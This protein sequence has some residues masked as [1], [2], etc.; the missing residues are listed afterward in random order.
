MGGSQSIAATYTK[1][2]TRQDLLSSTENNRDF[3][4]KLFQLLISQ[5]TSE[6]LL[7]LSKQ[8]LCSQYVFMMADTIHS[9]FDDLRIRP[10]TEKSSGVVLFKKVDNLK[11]ETKQTREICLTIAYFYV[12]IFQIFSAL[13][14]TVLDDPG[15]GAVLGAVQY[16]EQQ[17]A[18][19]VF[20]ALGLGQQQRIPG[21]RPA[22]AQFGG[23]SMQYFLGEAAK[24]F[25]PIH[26]LFEEG[27]LEQGRV[28]LPLRDYP[29]VVEIIPG[30]ISNRNRKPQNLRITLP[31]NSTLYGNIAA[32]RIGSTDSTPKYKL[33]LNNFESHNSSISALVAI[34]TQISKF[35]ESFEIGSFD[36]GQTWITQSGNAQDRVWMII[37]KVYQI[38]QKLVENP[39]LTLDK[40]KTVQ[41]LIRRKE[42]QVP[43]GPTRQVPYPTTEI[44]V[45]KELMN[46]Y[47]IK[48][49][50]GITEQKT[51]SFCVA[52]ALQLLNAD[53]LFMRNPTQAQSSIC[54][55]KF[56]QFPPSV[57][58]IGESLDK[59][60]GLKVLDQLFHTQPSLGERDETRI[61]VDD[62]ASYAEFL[63]NMI[64]LF[65][66]QATSKITS[67]DK[68][69]TRQQD[70]CASI[71]AS[72]QYLGITDKAAIQKVKAIVQTMFYR[73]L[74][75]TQQAIQF[76]RSRMFIIRKVK[77]PSGALVSTYDIHPRLLQ[78]G[79]DE[80]TLLSK[81]ARNILVKYYSDCE[82]LYQKGA[83]EIFRS[84]PN[85]IPA[86]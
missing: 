12:R 63:R 26:T 23:A 8:S 39:A 16:A 59:V 7:K 56:S 86:Q 6:D 29:D 82:D 33:I 69:I 81:D 14:V 85:V 17:P 84:R 38:I 78:G 28:V 64:Q 45:P 54:R 19:G 9:L 53:A 2:I 42:E 30:R 34:N 50:K 66:T 49:L 41:Q 40:L 71:S 4:N 43:S 73:Q 22:V 55:L 24:Q 1:Q 79:L 61:S 76:I 20:G 35:Q 27:K 83:L 44:G 15:A 51:I 37:D 70:G 62:P 11:K 32:F 65:G 58:Q 77:G 67:V 3:M 25:A 21:S 48:T 5:I 46:E 68:I 13:A 72:K 75:H 47:L 74:V 80:L 36:G 31:D 18:K 60:T 52:R 10:K 57:P